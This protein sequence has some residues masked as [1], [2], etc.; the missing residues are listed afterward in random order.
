[1]QVHNTL[2]NGFQEVIYQRCL[3]IEMKKQGLQFCRE[4]E[5]KIYYDNDRS[6]H[7]ASRFFSGE[8][9]HC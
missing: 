8:A 4:Y 3:S 5:M 2:G 7:A 1:M 9:N 6:G